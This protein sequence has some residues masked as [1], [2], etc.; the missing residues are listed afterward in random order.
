MRAPL[1]CAPHTPQ[2]T[3]PE[4]LRPDHRPEAVLLQ[5]PVSLLLSGQ[6]AGR[7]ALRHGEV[8][9][10]RA[11]RI[12]VYTALSFRLLLENLKTCLLQKVEE[13]VWACFVT[14]C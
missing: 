2:C 1:T 13:M 6:V 7:N 5:L 10:G 8:K 4:V 12:G 3:F 14:G 9:C 11:V